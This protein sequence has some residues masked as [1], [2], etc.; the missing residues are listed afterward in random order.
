ME[1]RS[2]KRARRILMISTAVSF[3]GALSA[4]IHY[5]MLKPDFD[6][7]RGTT[8]IVRNTP[9]DP[10]AVAPIKGAANDLFTQSGKR[11][12]ADRELALL[13]EAEASPEAAQMHFMTAAITPVGM[14]YRGSKAPTVADYQDVNRGGKADRLILEMVVSKPDLPVIPEEEPLQ[15][16]TSAALFLMAP[17]LSETASNADEEKPQAVSKSTWA[18]LVKLASVKGGDGESAKPNIFGSLTEKE[19]RAREFS[20]MATAIYF[21][22]RGEE[23]RGQ[24]AVAQVIMTRV[25]SDFYPNTICGVVY[26]G[27]WNRNACQFSFACDGKSDDPKNRK[28]WNVALD[29]AKKVISGQVYLDDVAD[30]THYHA[31]Y[32]KPDWR[33][34]VKKLTRIGVHIFYKADF[35][36]P[37]VANADFNN[38]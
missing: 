9:A 20:C 7:G 35:A 21:E 24:I 27:Q 32:V 5:G 3:M 18:D 25:R 8:S 17:P 16:G 31:T 23:I 2:A 37:L 29:V 34:M 14:P 33:K 13:P 12:R 15:E 4:F 6:D 30:A 19:F 28:Q 36:P 38:L 1:G 11:A 10:V 26:Q 22:A